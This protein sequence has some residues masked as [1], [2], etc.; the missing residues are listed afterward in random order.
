MYVR[1]E[2]DSPVGELAELSSLLELGSLLRVLYCTKK[3]MV[4]S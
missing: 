2:L 1:L 4:S 3:E